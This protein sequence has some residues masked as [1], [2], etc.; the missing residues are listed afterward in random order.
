MKTKIVF[1]NID[2]NDSISSYNDICND[3]DDAN[4]CQDKKEEEEEE[5]EGK[6]KNTSNNDEIPFTIHI[7]ILND[8][9]MLIG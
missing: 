8:I 1:V 9:T 5:E 7:N 6:F 3:N 4:L 2:T